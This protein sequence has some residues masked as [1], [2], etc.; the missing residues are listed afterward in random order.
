M[1]DKKTFHAYF[2]TS[3]LLKLY[4]GKLTGRRRAKHWRGASNSAHFSVSQEMYS[5]NNGIMHKNVSQFHIYATDVKC[6]PVHD[7]A[8]NLNF[9]T[10]DSTTT[11]L[12]RPAEKTIDIVAYITVMVENKLPI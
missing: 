12:Q 6:I 2:S 4:L 3:L 10:A 9:F 7:P 5:L 11:C 1:V 8:N